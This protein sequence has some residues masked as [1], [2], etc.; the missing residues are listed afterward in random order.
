M[1]D[2][3]HVYTCLPFLAGAAGRCIAEPL[4]LSSFY[5]ME[6]FILFASDQWLLVTALAA[7]IWALAWL[8]NRRAGTSLTPH[9]L[10]GM[11]NSASAVVIDLRD[12][13]DFEAGHIVDS[14]N[15]PFNQWQSQ[16]KAGGANELQRHNNKS[17]VLV[18]KMGQQSSH[19]ARRLRA[20][21]FEA[22]YRLGGGI[23][24]WRGAQMP[25]VKS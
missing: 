20:E 25:L 14:V 10:T 6:K 4:H 19:V 7:A 15:L 3:A 8:E 17:L 16:H 5:R 23:A 2:G 1:P 13:A 9:G 12:K 11:I 22:I 21:D 18:C 24:E